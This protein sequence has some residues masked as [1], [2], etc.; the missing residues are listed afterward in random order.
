MT[1]LNLIGCVGAALGELSPFPKPISIWL[2]FESASNSDVSELT[3]IV[4]RLGAAHLATS[5][6]EAEHIHDEIDECL[7]ELERDDVSTTWHHEDMAEIAWDLT[8]V[9]FATPATATILLVVI[10]DDERVAL[11]KLS[12]IFALVGVSME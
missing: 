3:S 12:E 1:A 4:L 10:S 2:H 6:I 11:Q 8:N 9:S 7:I 5:G